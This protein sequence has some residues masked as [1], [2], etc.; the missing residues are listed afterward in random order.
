MVCGK[1]RVEKWALIFRIVKTLLFGARM[2]VNQA[3]TFGLFKAMLILI[4]LFDDIEPKMDARTKNNGDHSKKEKV[5][6]CK[7]INSSYTLL[8]AD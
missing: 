1:R 8:T 4:Y 6:S 7:S 5:N 3:K 2:C